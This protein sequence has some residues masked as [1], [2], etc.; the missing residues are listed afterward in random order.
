MMNS[1]IYSGANAPHMMLC[2]KPSKLRSVALFLFL[3]TAAGCAEYTEFV[4][5]GSALVIGRPATKGGAG[6]LA[7]VE[8]ATDPELYD[9]VAGERLHVELALGSAPDLCSRDAEAYC[10]VRVKDQRVM[11]AAVGSYRT[12]RLGWGACPDAVLPVE[13][14]CK[15]PKLPAGTYD[16]IYGSYRSVK[17]VVPSRGEALSIGE[18]WQ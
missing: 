3:A 5:V 17:L 12:P 6:G 11:I 7:L 16:V 2:T 14:T 13:A 1:H 8:E 9:F 10:E 18:R 4:D 15:S